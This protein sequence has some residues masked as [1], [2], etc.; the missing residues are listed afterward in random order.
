MTVHVYSDQPISHAE[1]VEVREDPKVQDK[2]EEK[3]TKLSKTQKRNR[4][5][6]RK[7][8]MDKQQ[9]KCQSPLDNE[10]SKSD[11]VDTVDWPEA[12]QLRAMLMRLSKGE[13]E[14]SKDEVEVEDHLEAH[15]PQLTQELNHSMSRQD[16]DS[17]SSGV[18]P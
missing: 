18:E 2:E 17:W 12:A 3:K 5:S 10:I 7:A 8:V 14:H 9:E 16:A 4:Y 6:R 11:S 1:D 13:H 15:K